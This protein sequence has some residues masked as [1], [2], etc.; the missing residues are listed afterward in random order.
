MANLAYPQS[1]TIP[2]VKTNI[3][4]SNTGTTIHVVNSNIGA[5]TNTIRHKSK[6]IRIFAQRK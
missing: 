3:G 4:T 5:T 6:Y 1:Q 2:S